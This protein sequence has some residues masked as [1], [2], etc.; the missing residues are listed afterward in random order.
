M[1]IVSFDHFDLSAAPSGD[2]SGP[3]ES[4]EIVLSEIICF[5]VSTLNV[6]VAVSFPSAR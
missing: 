5:A 2:C 1:T 6:R 4:I 3:T